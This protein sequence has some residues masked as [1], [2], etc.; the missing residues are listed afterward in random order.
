MCVWLNEANKLKNFFPIWIIYRYTLRH[1]IGSTYL[2]KGW[3]SFAFRTLILGG[4]LSTCCIILLEVAFRRATILKID[5]SILTMFGVY[6]GAQSVPRKC[7]PT[8]TPAAAWR[9]GT[10]QDGSTLSCLLHILTTIWMFSWN[11]S[12]DHARFLQ[13]SIVRRGE[14][15]GVVS[16]S[17]C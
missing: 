6:Y 14:P 16:V 12:S 9:V 5:C 1:F 3:T 17:C 4:K 2:V 11:D 15:V 8:S 10:R 13:S 7:P